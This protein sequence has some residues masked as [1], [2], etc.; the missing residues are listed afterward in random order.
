L[1]ELAED[2]PLVCLVDDAHWLDGASASAL[3]FAAR[4]L[5]A[6]GIAII[7]AARDHNAVFPASGLRVLQLGGLDTASGAAVRAA[8]G[9]GLGPAARSRTRPE[10]RGTP[11]GLTELPAASL[12]APSAP[13]A[14]GW[15]GSTALALTDRL[16]QAF[17]GQIRR[18]P[19]DTRTILL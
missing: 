12:A 4:R 5:D 8:R 15:R 17:E 19:A 9:G 7:F 1:A 10:A 3:V 14:A 13:P 11:L 6:E 16:Q 2:R 18:L